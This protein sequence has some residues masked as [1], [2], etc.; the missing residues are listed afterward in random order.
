MPNPQIRP[1]SATNHRRRPQ[2]GRRQRPDRRD[3]PDRRRPPDAAVD[4]RLDC[5]CRRYMLIN[6]NRRSSGY[7]SRVTSL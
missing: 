7:Q 3:I 5:R 6:S 1:A 2:G 4:R